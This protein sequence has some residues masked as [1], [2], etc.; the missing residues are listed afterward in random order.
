MTAADL[1]VG[2]DDNAATSSVRSEI[3]SLRSLILLVWT[4]A[5]FCGSSIVMGNLALSKTT[6]KLSSAPVALSCLLMLTGSPLTNWC[7]NNCLLMLT[8]SPL[9]NWCSNNCF[10]VHRLPA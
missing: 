3:C 2:L 8:G 4:A 5:V 1:L 9:T 10:R 7:S 6:S